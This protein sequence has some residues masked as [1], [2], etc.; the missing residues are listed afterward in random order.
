MGL[1]GKF[2]NLTASSAKDRLA[3]SRKHGVADQ[4]ILASA[5]PQN[6]SDKIVLPEVAPV[7]GGAIVAKEPAPNTDEAADAI[8]HVGHEDEKAG[9]SVELAELT[10]ERVINANIADDTTVNGNANEEV[11]DESQFPSGLK[12]GLLTFGLCMAIFTVALDN[13]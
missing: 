2:R 13:T 9:E 12:L 11:E 8:K 10:P 7:G 6:T 3:P 4:E 1:R 5:T